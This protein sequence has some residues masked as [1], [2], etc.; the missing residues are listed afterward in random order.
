MH[1]LAHVEILSGVAEGDQVVV[2]GADALMDAARVAA[3]TRPFEAGG[4][5]L[6]EGGP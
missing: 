3:K 2:A 4:S 6:T 5:R 1:D